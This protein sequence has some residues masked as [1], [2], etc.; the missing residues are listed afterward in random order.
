MVYRGMAALDVDGTTLTTDHRVLPEVRSAIQSA[1]ADG[2]FITLATAR[3][4]LATRLVLKDLGPVDS[5]ICFGGALT[6]TPPEADAAVVET[7]TTDQI[8]AIADAAARLGV[9][10]SYYAI[11]SAYYET[12]DA[13]LEREFAA[14]AVDALQSDPRL[15]PAPVVKILAMSDADNNSGLVALQRQFGEELTV[16]F[17]HHSYLELMHR[18]ISKG[19]AVDALRE[20]LGIPREKLVTIGDS[21]N[22]LS[23]FAI[24]GRSVAMGNAPARIK[25]LANLTTHSNDEGGLADALD[26]CR[27]EIWQG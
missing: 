5:A 16:V 23:M 8:A 13:R 17:S 22:D 7:L 21:E 27:K 26:R 10:L 3:S 6:L 20:S 2:I 25:A 15:I 18:G 1:R 12:I 19:H 11:D 9:S 14:T 4:V 24:A